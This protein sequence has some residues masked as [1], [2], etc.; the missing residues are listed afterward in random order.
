ME[1]EI[2]EF[3]EIC[4]RELCNITPCHCEVRSNRTPKERS[5]IVRDCFVPRNDK[6]L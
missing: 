4:L 3:T 6:V 5:Y 2:T 1:G